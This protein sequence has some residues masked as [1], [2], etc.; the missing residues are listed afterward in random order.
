MTDQTANWDKLLLRLKSCA[1]R[2]CRG[3]GLAVVSVKLVLRDGELWGWTKPVPTYTEPGG[4]GGL[5]ELESDLLTD[6]MVEA[7]VAA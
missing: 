5:V 7:V 6:G 2:E 1:Y 4:R 3:H